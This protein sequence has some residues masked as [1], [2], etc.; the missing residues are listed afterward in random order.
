MRVFLFVCHRNLHLWIQMNKCVEELT[1]GQSPRVQPLALLAFF[2]QHG[3]E[4]QS[5]L[6][7]PDATCF[8]L[9]LQRVSLKPLFLVEG[10]LFVW[11]Q[12]KLGAGPEAAPGGP[13][14]TFP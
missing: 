5:A 2:E 1:T 13:E 11:K 12:E 3:A 6:P 8:L 7:D 10:R 4:S 9:A 14:A